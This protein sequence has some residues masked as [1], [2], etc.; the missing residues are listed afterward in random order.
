MQTLLRIIKVIRRKRKPREII[1]VRQMEPAHLL[2]YRIT[3][4]GRLVFKT[5]KR[6]RVVNP[7]PALLVADC[8]VA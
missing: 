7:G 6:E 1:F 3:R 2:V 4:V 5:V 8:R